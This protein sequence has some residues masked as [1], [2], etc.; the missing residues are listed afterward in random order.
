MTA[1][2][3]FG[4]ATKANPVGNDDL[5]IIGPGVDLVTLF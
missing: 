1:S 2:V 3:R 5:S 4:M